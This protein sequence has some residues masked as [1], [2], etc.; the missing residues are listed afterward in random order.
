M[1]TPAWPP[2]VGPDRFD[3]DYITLPAPLL[4]ELGT[5][6]HAQAEQDRAEA[7]IQA[8]RPSEPVR[9]QP[10]PGRPA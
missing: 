4:R 7:F 6:L 8:R 3:A 1:S 9:T 2:W 10:G 5:V